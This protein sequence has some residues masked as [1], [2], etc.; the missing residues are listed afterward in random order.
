MAHDP[1]T[2][3]PINDSRLADHR[4]KLLAFAGDLPHSDYAG[5]RLTFQL[6][7]QP[8]PFAPVAAVCRTF[9]WSSTLELMPACPI[10]SGVRK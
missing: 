8:L 7:A 4:R 10:A 2:R 5:H 3:E 9:D 6:V 1:A